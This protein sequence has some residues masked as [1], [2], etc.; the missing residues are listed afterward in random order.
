MLDVLDLFA[1]ITDVEG[2]ATFLNR[3]MLS[4][5]GIELDQVIG[6]QLTLSQPDGDTQ[7]AAF[8]SAIANE[9]IT[10]KWENEILIADR[11]HRIRWSSAFVRDEHD[12]IEAVASIGEDVTIRRQLEEQVR[13]A[14]R[15]ESLGRLGVAHDFN[16]ILTVIGGHAELLANAAELTAKSRSHINQ[17]VLGADR[18]TRLTRRL[19]ACGRQQVMDPCDVSVGE[20][21]DRLRTM[22]APILREDVVI[23]I[24]LRTEDDVVFIDPAQLDQVLLNLAINARDAM[25]QGGTLQLEVDTSDIH[26]APAALLGVVTGRYVTVAVADTGSGIPPELLGHIFEPFVTTKPVGAGTGLG[27]STAYGIITQSK[28]AI[29]VASRPGIGT[30]FTIHLPS[31][32]QPGDAPLPRRHAGVPIGAC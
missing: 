27:L 24:L 17:I 22:L 20:A 28:G 32:P 12:R 5:L 6:K 7:H 30:T 18:A 29:T 26:G 13:H 25:P 23:E 8:L 1:V 15:D 3:A 19:L 2:R 9:E 16:N 4:R 31:R 14:V 11:T 21:A 10:P